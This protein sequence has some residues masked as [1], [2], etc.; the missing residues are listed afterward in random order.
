MFQKNFGSSQIYLLCIGVCHWACPCRNTLWHKKIYFEKEQSQQP[1]LAQCF[2]IEAFGWFSFRKWRYSSG[3]FPLTFL[4]Q[5]LY[6][7]S[8]HFLC[9][10][11]SQ[12]I[13]SV[14]T[15]CQHFYS[16]KLFWTIKTFSITERR[17]YYRKRNKT[18]LWQ[19]FQTYF[20]PV[21]CSNY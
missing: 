8:V 20:F 15:L 2:D 9:T 17:Y 12:F 10:F 16:K 1:T 14:Y 18:N 3:D 13:D 5:L 11:D 4:A 6:A 21:K 7:L 19:D